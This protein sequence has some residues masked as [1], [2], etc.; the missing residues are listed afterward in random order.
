MSR[1][2]GDSNIIDDVSVFDFKG[3]Y[4]VDC[5][6]TNKLYSYIRKLLEMWFLWTL[7]PNIPST[8]SEM[9]VRSC[10]QYKIYDTVRSQRLLICCASPCYALMFT[11]ENQKICVNWVLETVDHD[12]AFPSN[13]SLVGCG[14]CRQWHHLALLPGRSL[15][16][17]HFIPLSAEN[18]QS[19]VQ[20]RNFAVSTDRYLSCY[21]YTIVQQRYIYTQCFRMCIDLARFFISLNSGQFLSVLIF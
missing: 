3:I 1:L 19:I 13:D 9:C 10:I 20:V 5:K 15:R 12:G 4:P 17:I 16:R 21:T 2:S 18:H 7:S 11:Y 6:C 14:H 8:T